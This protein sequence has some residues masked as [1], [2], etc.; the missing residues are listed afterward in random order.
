MD[1]KLTKTLAAPDF[2]AWRNTLWKEISAQAIGEGWV[3]PREITEDGVI[4]HELERWATLWT[5]LVSL[6][7]EQKDVV[8]LRESSSS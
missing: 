4:N 6:D 3:P 2:A 7:D 8:Y 1:D 5:T